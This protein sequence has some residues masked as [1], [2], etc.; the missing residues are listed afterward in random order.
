[1]RFTRNAAPAFATDSR[2]GT[3]SGLTTSLNLRGLRARLSERREVLLERLRS[4][5]LSLDELDRS[6]PIEA[7]EEA[8]E[9]NIA[10]P[11]AA[12]DQRSR[13]E[14]A[15]ID[16][17]ITRIDRGE[18]GICETCDEPIRPERLLALPSTVHCLECAEQAERQRAPGERGEPERRLG[19]G[20]DADSGTDL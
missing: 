16:D 18:Y 2:T 17:A 9:L 4:A 13:T 20:S 10:R 8:Q 14:P 12:L 3:G 11:Q 19:E 6:Q 7:E 5:A 1:M 15:E